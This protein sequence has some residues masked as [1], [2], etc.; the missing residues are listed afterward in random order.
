MLRLGRAILL[1]PT[2]DLAREIIAGL[3]E[4][5]KADLFGI[6]DVQLRQRLDLAGEDLAAH[7]WRLSRQRG[8]PKHPALFH[9]HDVEGGPNDP[10]I[11]AKRIG[12]RDRKAL[13]AERR[14]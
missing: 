10:V 12:P 5:A 6:V 2:I 14:N 1:G 4:I 3:A 9:R 8:I 7:L 13:L 11:G